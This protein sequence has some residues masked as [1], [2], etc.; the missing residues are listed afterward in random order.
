[1]FRTWKRPQRRRSGLGL[2]RQCPPAFRRLQ[3]ELLEDRLV[4]ASAVTL[5]PLQFFGDF[6]TGPDYSA[7]GVVQL[8]LAPTQGEDFRPL[9]QIN[10]SV[11]FADGGST[12][13]VNG[14]IISIIQPTPAQVALWQ[15]TATFT[16]SDLVGSGATLSDAL[17]VDFHQGNGA[18]FTANFVPDTLILN[19]PDGG[20]TS[21]SVVQ[22]QGRFSFNQLVGFVAPVSESFFIT[23]NDTGIS[24]PGT[25]TANVSA[26]GPN[27]RFTVFG[28]A[29]DPSP[30]LALAFDA[31]SGRFVAY[32]PMG[33]YSADGGI[34]STAYNLGTRPEPGLILEGG[35]VV[36]LAVNTDNPMVVFGL[37]LN[38]RV[39]TI[40]YNPQLHRWE[41]YGEGWLNLDELSLNGTFG[42]DSDPGMV[43]DGNSG[44]FTTIRMAIPSNFQ[45]GPLSYDS[46]LT[47]TYQSDSTYAITGTLRVPFFFNATATLGAA[48]HPGIL[49]HNGSVQI[50]DLRIELDDV[51]LGAFV[52]DDLVVAYSKQDSDIEVE[53]GGSLW[54]P[55]ADKGLAMEIDIR[56]GQLNGIKIAEHGVQIPVGE[57]GVFIT[58]IDAEIKNFTQPSDLYVAGSVTITWGPKLELFGKAEVSLFKATG[59]FSVDRNHLELGGTFYIGAWTNPADGTTE[60]L[61]AKGQVTVDLNWSEND[62]RADFEVDWFDGTFKITATL[63]IRVGS[64]EEEIF[65]RGEASVNVPDFI[66]FIGGDEIA[67]VDFAFVYRPNQSLSHS[68]VAAWT[69]IDL[70]VDDVEIGVKVDFTGHVSV[71]G[72][73]DI[74]GIKDETR[75]RA[76]TQFEYSSNFPVPAGATRLVMG[77]KWPT[78]GGKQQLAVTLPN[79]KTIPESQF[80]SAN[81]ISVITNQSKPTARYVQI[82]G[83][84]EF[85][86]IASGVY[87]LT[88]ISSGVNQYSTPPKFTSQVFYAK[89]QAVLSALPLNGFGAVPIEIRAKADNALV[90]LATVSLYVDS[91]NQGYDGV[92]IAGAQN[93][94]LANAHFDSQTKE[95]VIPTTWNL[96]GLLPLP[97]Y[98]YAVIHDGVNPPVTSAYTGPMTA[99]PPLSGY[100]TDV[101]PGHGNSGV[102]GITVFLDSNNNNVYDPGID[103]STVTG[104]VG[105]YSFYNLASGQNYAVGIVIP[106][107]YILAPVQGNTNPVH[108]QYQG[109][110]SNINF[111]LYKL[112]SISG[113]VYADVNMNGQRDDGEPGQQGWTVTLSSNGT[114]VATAYTAPDGSYTFYAVSPGTYTVTLLPQV[115]YFQ[116]GPTPIPPGTYTATIAPTQD[117]PYPQILHQDFGVVPY[118]R[119]TGSV[120]GHPLVQ[121]RLDTNTVPL[122]GWTIELLQNGQVIRTTTSASDGTYSF[123]GLLPG[124]Y[125]V[126]QI[127]PSGWRQM[128][129]FQSE[130]RFAN[131]SF[132][133]NNIPHTSPEPATAIVVADFDGDG[134]LD[135]ATP[136][137][138]SSENVS[139]VNVFFGNGDGTFTDIRSFGVSF[140][141]INNILAVDISGTGRPDLIV[142]S[143]DGWLDRLV[144]H[145]NRTFT[146]QRHYAGI[147]TPGIS[148]FYMTAADLDNDGK[149]DW[150][151]TYRQN[152]GDQGGN[153]PLVVAI[154]NTAHHSWT[155]LTQDSGDM[156]GGVAAGDIN[157]DGWI[158]LFIASGAY[159][160]V[161]AGLPSVLYN[162]GHGFFKAPWPGIPALGSNLGNTGGGAALGDIDGDGWLDGAT[163]STGSFF[164]GFVNL[165]YNS[166]K[167]R[168]VTDST[169][170]EDA[171]RPN[172]KV[173]LL[174][175]DGDLRLDLVNL[176]TDQPWYFHTNLGNRQYAF[177][178]T[179]RYVI[180]GARIADL[181]F[182]DLNGDG[183][184]DMLAADS[185]L[186]GT[187]IFLNNSV[188]NESINLSL[189][190]F[191]NGLINFVNGQLGQ[192]NGRVFND[193][194]RDGNEIRGEPGLA[195]VTVYLD[196]NGNGQFDPDEPSAVTGPEGTYAF[197]NLPDGAYQVRVVSGP[198]RLTTHPIGFHHAVIA[199]GVGPQELVNFGLTP[200]LHRTLDMPAAG[201]DWTILRKGEWVEI[202]QRDGSLIERQRIADV[203]SIT[204]NGSNKS[205]RLTIDLAQGG[206]FT[207]PGGITFH[208]GSGR[209]DVF[210]YI[211][212]S[213]NDVI[214]LTGQTATVER[215]PNGSWTGIE[216]LVVH[217]GNGNDVIQV[218][219]R[220]GSELRLLGGYGDDTYTLATERTNLR[221]IDVGGK[222]KLDFSQAT[223][224]V[225]VELGQRNGQRQRIGGGNTLRLEG[226]WEILVGSAFNDALTAGNHASVLLGLGG[227][228]LLTAGTGRSLLIGGPGRDVLNG[229]RDDSILVSDATNHDANDSAL[230][231]ILAEWASDRPRLQRI[232]N[233]TGIGSG[234]RLNGDWFLDPANLND[235][236]QADSLRGRSYDWFLG[237]AQDLFRAISK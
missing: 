140:P 147:Q 96:T 174:D 180:S 153:P 18:N 13:D 178:P 41:A 190:P 161:Q 49:I 11:A 102:P 76:P 77:V 86:P 235:D 107:G 21:D 72:S 224:G 126:R 55:V 125:T 33:L 122:E 87:Q 182:G 118:S 203:H 191:Q 3:L 166:G 157:R 207:L 226:K 108:F 141:F 189:A 81:G 194:N 67:G 45:L 137:R 167:G 156:P 138:V 171:D 214:S 218:S 172:H 179:E 230:L 6:N 1:M 184:I 27:H 143:S 7:N 233:L 26:T 231:A 84:D 20:S 236:G 220:F 68:F 92:P 133:S 177:R 103:P 74:D 205:D 58:G 152:I 29:M 115:D 111:G 120:A 229:G 15:G 36:S 165:Y 5:G 213:G 35:A 225:R 25:Y 47:L 227:D 64:G 175:L 62:Y 154:F 88:L 38:F 12:F 132:V 200:H 142:L 185:L 22:L 52:L 104:P 181:A 197:S 116:S 163:G 155:T 8:G 23:L 28:L 53:F 124:D 30:G 56:N 51:F 101:A 202:R 31:N 195:G 110:F 19:N 57:T 106:Y 211:L 193:V 173:F 164:P 169:Y 97:Y 89:P 105:Y 131:P 91:D 61:L 139:G 37:P 112:P 130:L 208:G 70:L 158:D 183:L 10:G 93:L 4:P 232:A 17:T 40:S 94:P 237:S 135:F 151:I 69:D 199:A 66:P 16:V 127:V 79:G 216:T 222:D 196:L 210:R 75:Q 24:L 217:A 192:I 44:A 146:L 39:P 201:G 99:N 42:D 82:V 78:P 204:I 50:D 48:G 32:G 117:D 160:P 46:N 2:R 71:I 80:S 65:F 34:A 113:M 121:G 223:H 168:L 228:D 73:D 159:D 206:Y 119:V 136:W 129:P 83:A 170:F 209:N 212:G 176:P 109:G 9:V 149:E 186:N 198:N 59:E 150:V 219:G 215:G 162:Q 234:D 144:N 221:L 60:A 43:I 128:S 95:Y 63:D 100:V 54:L 14:S 148:P 114:D 188:I 85:T 90:P 123:S 145:G 187:H 98:V 134:H